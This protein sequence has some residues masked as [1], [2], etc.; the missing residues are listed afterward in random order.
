[1]RIFLTGGTGFIGRHLVDRLAEAGHACVVVSRA[2]RTPWKEGSVEVVQGDPTRPGPWQQAVR[3]CDAVVNLAG[4]PIV[5]PPHR[6]TARRKR[7]LRVSRVA[8]TRHVVQAIRAAD[9]A[10]KILLSSSAIGYYGPRGDV[11]LDESAP[12]GDDFL[13]ELAVEWENAAREIEDRCRVVLLRSGLVLGTDGGALPKLLPVFKLGLG[14]PWGPGTQWW[15]WIHITDQV[16]LIRFLLDGD[17]AGPVNLVAP[18]AVTVNS[19]AAELGRALHRPAILR[20]PAVALRLAL[21]EAADAL[22]A[23]QRVTPRRALEAG[24]RFRF[25]ELPAA[26]DDLL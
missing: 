18:N 12:P 22:L 10:P 8:T 1:M 16:Q 3:G 6:W 2:A 11:V 21:G 13:S 14:G 26:L 20:V 7:L 19:F 15:S 17:L 23:L 24:Y 9:P 4:A 5:D 25:P